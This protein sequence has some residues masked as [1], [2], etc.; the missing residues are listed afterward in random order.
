[1]LTKRS[2]E[3]LVLVTFVSLS[4]TTPA[5]VFADDCGDQKQPRQLGSL[6]TDAEVQV[7]GLRSHVTADEVRRARYDV[8]FPQDNWIGNTYELAFVDKEGKATILEDNMELRN[9][10]LTS[11]NIPERV[12]DYLEMGP[13][14]GIVGSR[15]E[16][17]VGETYDSV[18]LRPEGRPHFRFTCDRTESVAGI[19]GYHLVVKSVRYGNVEMEM[20]LSPA[21]PFPLALREYTG[22]HPLAITL[23][24]VGPIQVAA[25]E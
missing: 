4:C 2:L 7:F 10:D 20:V 3:A 1:M 16:F 24:D 21:F 15:R 17:V 8:A 13:L 19:Q 25:A 23:R 12:K 18:M 5:S 22:V 14:L 6:P 11:P 9:S